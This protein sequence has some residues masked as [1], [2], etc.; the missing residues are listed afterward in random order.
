MKAP[1]AAQKRRMSKVVS[2]GCI[3]CLNMGYYS[4]A[5]I[6]HIRT[7]LGMGQRDHDRIIGLCFD[8]HTGCDG[9]HCGQKEWESR[10][11]SELELEVQIKTLLGE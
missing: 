3:P 4:P 10:H 6:H 7:G 1:T 5:V 9:I 8:H 11:G 2:L